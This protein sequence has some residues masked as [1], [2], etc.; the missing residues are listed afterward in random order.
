MEQWLEYLTHH[1]VI[2]INLFALFVICAGTIEAFANAVRFLFQ[3]PALG[4]LT[5]AWLR[6]GRALVA[7]LTFQLA[8]DII[9]SASAPDWT[10]IGQ[11]GAIAVIR[12]FLNFFLDR[13]LKEL[14]ERQPE[15]PGLSNT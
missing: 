5:L 13:D 10:R 9:E 15:T 14:R 11:L 12:T 8:A 1:A 4:V 6:Y 2:I 7:G 3:R